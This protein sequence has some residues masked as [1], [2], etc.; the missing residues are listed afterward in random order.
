M[1]VN[2]SIKNNIGL[3]KKAAVFLL[4]VLVL[5]ISAGII[6]VTADEEPAVYDEYGGGYA[7]TG[8]LEGFGYTTEIYDASNGLPTSDANYVLGT[9]AGYV[10]IGGYS[11]I[12]RYDGNVFEK[13]TI[14]DGLTSGRCIFEDSKGRIWVGTND[15]GIVIITNGTAEHITY[16]EG[17]PASSIRSFAED[18][19]GNIYAGTTAGLCYL[20]DAMSIHIVDDDRI[21][22][23]RILRVV[24]DSSGMI[25][26]LT[27]SGA[28]FS[29]TDGV[30]DEYYESSDLGV[31]EI[32]SL[33]PDP[34]KPGVFYYGTVND[35]IYY[36]PFGYGSKELKKIETEGVEEIHWMSYD[37]GRVWIVTP[38]S[39]GFLDTDFSFHIIDNL[40]MTS[41]IEMVT[42]DYQGNMW[43]ASS[44]QGVMKVVANNFSNITEAAGIPEDVVSATYKYG[45]MLYIGTDSGLYI[46]DS[47]MNIVENDLTEYIGNE[48]VRCIKADDEGNIWVCTYKGKRGLVCYH[49]DGTIT[50]YTEAD[51]LPSPYIRNITFADDGSALVGTNGGLAIIKYGVVMRVVTEEDGIK[52]T[53]FLT[54]ENG[55]DG[56]IIVGSDGDGM[57]VID[58]DTVTHLG[59]DDGLTSDVVMRIKKDDT[60]G[61]YWIVTS[62]S[63]EY[64]K[65]GV[66]TNVTS[67]PINNNY[68]FYFD[69]KD[70]M[71]ILSSYGIYRV[72]AEDVLNNE[73]TNYRLYTLANGMTGTP[74][75]NSYSALD[76]DGNL[77]I[78]CRNGVTR[79]NINHYLEENASIKTDIGSLMC[80]N[81]RILPGQD[82]TY[83]IPKGTG[84]I[85]ICCSVLDYTMSNPTVH[86]FLEGSDDGITATR[87]K[88]SA[89][90]YTG[91]KYGNY[92]LHIEIIDDATG[93]V[94]QDDTFNIIKQPKFSE[95]ILV[96]VLFVGLL[97]MIA[98]FV[99]WRV[100]SGTVIKKQYEDIKIAK[101]EAERASTAKTRFLANISHEIRTPINT[102]MGMNEMV[103]REDAK[104][105]PKGYFMSVINYSLDIRNASEA[106]LSLINDLLDMSKIES[107]K[108][109]LVEQ[110]YNTE[111]ILRS[112]VSMIRVR[113]SQKGLFF[114]VDVDESIPV[115]MYGDCGKIKQITL[116]LLTNAVKY[117]QKGGFSL[118]V[119]MEEK[120]NDS[121]RIRISVKD[122]G[123]GIKEEDRDKLFTAYQR[124]DEVKNSDIQGTGLGLDI[125]MKFAQILGGT[126]TCESKYGEGSEFVLTITQKIVDRK[127][128][129]AFVERQDHNAGPYKPK[130]IA[131][132]ADILVVD[133]NPMNLEVIKGLLKSTKMFITTAMS[134][135]ECLEKIRYGRFNMVFLDHMM[136]GMDGIETL[137][138]IRENYPDLPVYALTANSTAGEDYY[139]SKGFDG[140]LTKPID[141]VILERIILK[142]LPSGIVQVTESEADDEEITEI[143]EDFLWV[144]E[145]EG[146]NVDDGIKHSGSIP[147]FIMSVKMFYETIDDNSGLIEKAFRAGDLRMF[148]IKVHSLKTSARIV[149][150]T[151]LSKRAE[152]LEN[153]GNRE[154]KDYINK[155]ALGFLAEYRAFKEKLKKAG[156]ENGAD[157]KPLIDDDMLRDGLDT[158]KVVISQ[159]D[160][161]SVEMILD[162]LSEYKLPD[163]AA[164]VIAELNKL[165]RILDWDKM[166]EVIK[167]N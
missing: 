53:V 9:T 116:N 47:D 50:G 109:N 152:E 122:T 88:L 139:I 4:V 68:D 146:L 159:M 151:D 84:R 100:M 20:D 163:D 69:D 33:L 76:D 167:A 64:M 45:D 61:V 129:G 137:E 132:E 63:I 54:V 160:A 37:C 103:M 166:E 153:A 70:N 95:L 128:I 66:I 134:G 156:E 149:G 87:D 17:L 73:V 12:F 67:F 15:N 111:E 8:Q 98:G 78:S 133:D 22:N 77:Y 85:Q 113:S 115:R 27:G 96:K 1:R 125:S 57:Y 41:A 71:W 6:N 117:T 14:S 3:I 7:V 105:V 154:D 148:T 13:V 90:E 58:G 55:D 82:G 150:A 59:R 104:D 40:P 75:S 102:I 5:F 94:V 28:V 126:L 138:R 35:Y 114:D 26:G 120:T 112:I 74:T 118:R 29:V 99:V 65:D 32:T 2:L 44:T 162:Q 80:N 16:K 131:P 119:F 157:D 107:G 91:L 31:N 101:E 23:D 10:W 19:L 124:L 130:F 89:L 38:S 43:F 42:S 25:Y 97:V 123:M 93:A 145:V 52:N 36:G 158:L 60:R 79:V 106:L 141:T 21:N 140:Y 72:S 135:P 24:S 49:P 18:S 34:E 39:A 51:G 108:M 136:P 110:E 11:G 62:N 121:C 46:L 30:I 143:P 147:A 144:K 142:H 86:V 165:F 127:A 164:G 56:E 81:E 155:T 92:V 161:G 48:R 83:V